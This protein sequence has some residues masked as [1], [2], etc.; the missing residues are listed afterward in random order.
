[1]SKHHP[2]LV[3]CRKQPGNAVGRACKRCE[4]KC[5]LCDTYVRP[6]KQ[7][8]ICNECNFGP[9]EGKCVVRESV[10]VRAVC[11]YLCELLLCASFV[12]PYL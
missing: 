5:V 2:D 9:H 4:G 7:V 1:M 11:V 12:Y 6:T 3:L 10:C 8:R